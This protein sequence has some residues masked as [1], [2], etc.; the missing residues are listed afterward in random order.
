M[1]MVVR[2]MKKKLRS[3]GGDPTMKKE[4]GKEEEKELREILE[5]NFG[6]G[7]GAVL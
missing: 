1:E 6:K 2:N 4:E 7:W 5:R 3:L